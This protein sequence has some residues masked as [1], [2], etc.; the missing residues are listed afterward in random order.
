MV[1][2]FLKLSRRN[3]STK[4]Q[5]NMRFIK[6]C[7]FDRICAWYLYRGSTYSSFKCRGVM[8][9]PDLGSSTQCNID[10]MVKG[11]KCEIFDGSGFMM[12]TLQSFPGWA[13]LGVK[14][15][16]NILM[17]WGERHH[18][19][20]YTQAEHTQSLCVCSVHA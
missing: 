3:L 19:F 18:L 9:P 4:K 16:L 14:Y 15:K 10:L 11:P 7:L 20:S 17:F 8:G 2:F 12:F 13:S 5:F 6:L 1:V